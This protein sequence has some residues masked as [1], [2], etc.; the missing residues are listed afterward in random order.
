MG[1]LLSGT[2]QPAPQQEHKQQL[3]THVCPAQS[4]VKRGL[5]T[6]ITVCKSKKGSE[7]NLATQQLQL[8]IE[9]LRHIIEGMHGAP[10]SLALAFAPGTAGRLVP[11]SKAIQLLRISLSLQPCEAPCSFTCCYKNSLPTYFTKLSKQLW[12]KLRDHCI[13]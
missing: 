8:P 5:F 10:Q 13:F 12:K 9:Q 3:Q 6:S 4:G 11:C 1:S 7:D 2:T